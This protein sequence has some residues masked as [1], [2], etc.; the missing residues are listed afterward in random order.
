MAD[1]KRSELENR[2]MIGK[3]VWF[4]VKGTADRELWGTVEDEVNI[5]V[6]DD[7]P[8]KHMIQRIRTAEGIIWDGSTYIYRTGYYTFSAKEPRKIIWASTLKC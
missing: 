8:Y 7:D 5:L 2:S 1:D 3:G 6:G 4:K